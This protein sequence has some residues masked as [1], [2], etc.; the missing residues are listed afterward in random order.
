VHWVPLQVFKAV[1]RR[2]YPGSYLLD[3]LEG[4][5]RREL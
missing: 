1:I 4:K 2:D 3:G 5:R